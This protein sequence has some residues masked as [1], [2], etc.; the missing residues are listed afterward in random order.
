M[1]TEN[2][3]NFDDFEKE[4]EALLSEQN[5]SRAAAL[6]R[7]RELNIFRSGS[8]P[9][10]VEGSRIAMQSL[11]LSDEEMRAHPDYLSYYYGNDNLNPRMPPP[12]VSR[13]DWR[14]AQRFRTAKSA[15]GDRRT[16]GGGGSLFSVQP[17]LPRGDDEGRGLKE[18]EWGNG[19]LIGL[20]DVGLGTRRKSFADVIQ[21]KNI[22]FWAVLGVF[23]IAT[24]VFYYSC[25]Q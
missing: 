18:K 20:G 15:I 8:A 25:Y 19:G 24:L 14:V 4:L 23:H 9:P 2:S 17:G 7:E 16:N 13:E 10:T 6:D 11:V 1:I 22:I 21:V 12:L 3:S 5:N